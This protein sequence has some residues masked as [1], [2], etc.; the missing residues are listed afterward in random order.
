VSKLSPSDD[1]PERCRFAHG[2]IRDVVY[3]ELSPDRRAHLHAL[4]GATVERLGSGELDLHCRTLAHHYSEA[5]P[6]GFAVKALEYCLHVARV[7]AAHHAWE[8]A[9]TNWERG[10]SLLELLPDGAAER[11]MIAVGPVCEDLGDA[12]ALLGQGHRAAGAYERAILHVAPD[13]KAALAR[14]KRKRARCGEVC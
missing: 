13:E 7:A 12:L 6:V 3:E 5:V 11:G 8:E 14:L 10:L 1:A 2:L 4:A 9:C